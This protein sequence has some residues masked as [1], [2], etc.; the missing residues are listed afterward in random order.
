MKLQYL[1]QLVGTTSANSYYKASG[2]RTAQDLEKRLIKQ[3]R[4][5]K[6]IQGF[7]IKVMDQCGST[8][9]AYFIHNI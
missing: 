6:A 8:L 4:T 5:N 7:N 3:Y 9:Q 1:F 2:V